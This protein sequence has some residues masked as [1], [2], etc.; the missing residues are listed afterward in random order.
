MLIASPQL[1]GEALPAIAV[2]TLREVVER[3]MA[4]QLYWWGGE[5]YRSGATLPVAIA[6]ELRQFI[7]KVDNFQT[8]D[9][10]RT[11]TAFFEG[12]AG[13]NFLYITSF[14]ARPTPNGGTPLSEWWKPFEPSFTSPRLT[15][16]EVLVPAER[17]PVTLPESESKERVRRSIASSLENYL[18][19]LSEQG[20]MRFPQSTQVQIADFNVEDQMTFAHDVSSGSVFEILICDVGDATDSRCVARSGLVVNEVNWSRK[21]LERLR[22]N[23]RRRGGS[24]INVSTRK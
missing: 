7:V 11:M 20:I 17:V 16:T 4:F 10:D 23:I 15:G 6:S 24:T 5:Q 1:R 14:S 3:R 9:G 12:A 13:G 19:A 2:D 18:S 22:N 8:I 21:E